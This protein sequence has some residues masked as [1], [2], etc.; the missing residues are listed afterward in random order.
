MPVLVTAF[1]DDLAGRR[2]LVTRRDNDWSFDFGD[3]RLLHVSCPW[4]LVGSVAIVLADSDDRQ[5]FGRK[6]PVDAEVRANA[7]LAG[8]TVERAKVDLITADLNIWL[9]GDMRFDVFNN[10]TGYE[11]WQAG[12]AAD[13]KMGGIV[14]LG[15]GKLAFV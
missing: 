4:R 6:T 14:A 9:T 1:E 15:G 7:L 12:Y 11:G 3:K 5:L 2:C 10:S 8:K 13:G